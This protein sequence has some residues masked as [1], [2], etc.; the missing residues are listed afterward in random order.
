LQAAD[1]LVHLVYLHMTERV[2]EGER[3]NFSRMPTELAGLCM[4]NV[5]DQKNEFVYQNKETL[6]HMIDTAK[7]ISPRWKPR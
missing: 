3:G 1:L 6:Q 4:A 5:R 7:V 2:G